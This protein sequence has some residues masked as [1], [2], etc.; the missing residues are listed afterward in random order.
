MMQNEVTREGNGQDAPQE[1]AQH[2]SCCIVGGGPAGAV[3]ALLLARQSVPV[4]LLETHMDFEREFRG[5]TLHPGVME[6][7]DDIGLAEPLLTLRHTK[8]RQVD[9]QSPA[10]PVKV[11]LGDGFARLKTK[12]PYITVMAQ[13]QFLTFITKE[14]ARYPDFHLVMGAQADALIE[15]DGVV[16]GVRYRTSHGEHEVRAPL[17]V[18]ADGRFSRLRKL[19]G[20]EPVKTSPPIDVLWFRLSRRKADTLDALDARTGHGL[21]VVLID[22]FDYWQVGCVISK[23]QYHE[24][25]EAG[26]ESFRH[27]F[28]QAV[29]ELADRIGELSEWK[30]VSVLSVESNRLKQWYAPGLLFIGDAAHVMSPVGGVGINYAI[31]DAVVASN[32]LGPRLRAGRPIEARELAEVQHQRELPTR[33]IQLFQTLAQKLVMMR[34]KNGRA[35]ATATPPRLLNLLF[36][37]SWFLALPAWFIGFGLHT[38]RVKD[39]NPDGRTDRTPE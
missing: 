32:V 22:R 29:P 1:D 7:L 21:F 26:L 35:T 30:Q 9:V 39:N 18:A 10:G 33:A 36:Q 12:F 20:R 23:G 13:S 15:E 34:L 31:F 8:V 4:I 2:T 3:L 14:A 11:N 27:S 5:D 38:P 19:A 37:S 24:L 25:R 28:A 6:I 17:V 16:R